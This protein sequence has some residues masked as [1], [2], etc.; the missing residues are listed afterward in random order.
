ML[1]YDLEHRGSTPLYQYLYHCLRQ[2]IRTGV[3]EADTK[4]PSKRR[5]AEHL[6]VSVMTVESAYEQLRAEGYISAQSKQGFFVCQTERLEPSNQMVLASS[7]V[8]LPTWAL[9]LHTN[10]VDA[11][12]FPF[13]TWSKLV[14]Q[15]L[16]QE[17]T[18][19]LNPVPPQGL[20]I[21]R[22]AI[23]EDLRQYRGMVVA[24]EQ[25]IVGAG[26][27]YLY[28]VLAQLLGRQH[29]FG[30]E[31]PGYGKIRRVYKS[32][33]VNVHP[34]A[35]DTQGL[36]LD[37]LVQAPVTVAHL[38]PSHQYPTGAVMPIARR[39]G[40]LRWAQ[41]VDGY[42]I[43]DDYDSE[44]R[45]S[46]R[47]LPSL[48]SIDRHGRVIYLNTFSQTIA[49][50]MRLGFLVLPPALLTMYH[51]RLNFYASTV[52]TMEQHVLARFL[53]N[54]WYERHLSR[55]RKEYRLRRLAVL[56]AF[57]SCPF[58]HRISIEEQGAGLHFLMK[59]DTTLTDEALRERAR[60]QGVRFGFLSDYAT[61][62][63]HQYA[64]TL[65]VNYA[66]LDVAQLPQVIAQL[67]RLLEE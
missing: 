56:S 37:A 62:S 24:P 66:A 39:Q 54:G 28:L 61:Q 3:L 58:A 47:P 1:T 16:S 35:L 65:V 12:L 20:S 18:D 55:M 41:A 33:G 26:A 21:L 17:G 8:A 4:L 14:R 30:V 29:N 45:L 44:L 34:I 10:H 46:G 49:P 15:V 11:T 59:V 38:S 57:E 22:E 36:R 23:A 6:G 7:A 5:F 53:A 43:E 32:A 60:L 42:I 51:D 2:D 50:S 63:P 25:I 64:H 19:L 67:G 9:D 27:E 48:Q 13:A 31:D 40:L 52:P